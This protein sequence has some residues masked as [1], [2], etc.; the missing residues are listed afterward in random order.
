MR[1]RARQAA[2]GLQRPA[3]LQRRERGRRHQHD[4]TAC[5]KPL[6]GVHPPVLGELVGGGVLLGGS[7]GGGHGG[8]PGTP[9]GENGPPD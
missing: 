2:P 6:C 7:V 1:R 9:A 3:A 8:L 5:S 4:V